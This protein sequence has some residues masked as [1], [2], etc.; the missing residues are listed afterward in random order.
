MQ[1][2]RLLLQLTQAAAAL[3][4]QQVFAPSARAQAPQWADWSSPYAVFTLGVASGEPRPHSVVLWT[5]LAPRPMQPDGGMPARAIP[6]RWTVASDA[7]FAQVVQSGVVLAQPDV[8][9]SVHVE[10]TGLQP[11]RTYFYRFEAGGQ[12]SPPGRTATAPDPAD[13]PKRLRVALA[14][15]QHLEAGYYA[16]HREI[17]AADV[18]LV[19][20]VGDYIYE[21]QMPSYLRVR[22]HPHV[23]DS[24]PEDYTLADYRAH[25]ASYKRDADLQACHAAHPW[26]MIWDDHEVLND[27]AGV[28]APDVSDRLAF[29]RLRTMAYRAYFEHLPVSPSRMPVGPVMRMQDRYEWGQLAEFWLVDGRQHRDRHVCRG[30]HAPKRGSLLWRCEAANAPER[31]LMGM[32][33]ENW[34]ADGLASSTRAWKFI[35]QPTQISP[36]AIKTPLGPLAYADGWDAYPAARERLMAAIAQPRV[37]DVICLGGDVHRHVAANLR[38]NPMDPA[39]PVVATEF[40]TSSVTSKGLGEAVNNWMKS[41]NPDLLHMRSDE[42]GYTLLDIS[43]QQV[44]CEFR[45]TPHPVRADARLHTQARFVV[46]RGVPGPRKVE[47][48]LQSPHGQTPVQTAGSQGA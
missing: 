17:A 25:H 33:Q 4:W 5:R 12:P 27:Y 35:V 18:D 40:V 20:F 43:P 21:T 28:T 14:S 45:G 34:L 16:V 38:F 8:A 31:T 48:L 11:A 6:V 10:V 2:R 42:R 19:L 37:P 32:D 22:K 7:R 24:D 46:E 1:R 41:S 26:L 9:H 30:L 47:G 23:F 44:L 39:S 13:N 3:A 15:C 29:L 36:A